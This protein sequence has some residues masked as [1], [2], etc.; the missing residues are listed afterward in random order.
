MSRVGKKLHAHLDNQVLKTEHERIIMVN[1]IMNARIIQIQNITGF[2][3]EMKVFGAF[4]CLLL[5]IKGPRMYYI[6]T[7]YICK[8]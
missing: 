5:I 2:V 7:C 8:L 1:G 3:S 6:T 4:S